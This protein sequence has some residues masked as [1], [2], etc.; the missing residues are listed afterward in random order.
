MASEDVEV[1]AT[2]DRHIVMVQYKNQLG[3]AFHPELCECTMIH[4]KFIQ[5]M[6]ENR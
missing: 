1:L 6:I 3:K 4:K 5:L 2:V